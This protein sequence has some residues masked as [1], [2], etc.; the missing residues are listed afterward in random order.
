MDSIYVFKYVPSS[1]KRLLYLYLIGLGTP[2]SKLIKEEYDKLFGANKYNIIV[3]P[4]M[5]MYQD[6]DIG[7]MGLYEVIKVSVN[8]FFK[9]TA[10]PFKFYK[11]Y[12]GDIGTKLKE[13]LLLPQQLYEIDCAKM[14]Y[15]YNCSNAVKYNIILSILAD[16]AAL[17]KLFKYKVLQLNSEEK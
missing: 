12:T 9:R 10:V 1:V 6:K 13:D 14:F 4:H 2:T 8:K 7:F 15:V 5:S 16:R 11:K 17:V 3:Y